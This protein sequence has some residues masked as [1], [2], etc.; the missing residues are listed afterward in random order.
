MSPDEIGRKIALLI[1]YSRDG[2]DGGSRW[3][4]E[5]LRELSHLADELLKMPPWET[6]V[7]IGNSPWN[8]PIPTADPCEGKPE[9]NRHGAGPF[10]ARR[11]RSEIAALLSRQKESLS[12]T[13]SK[14]FEIMSELSG[15]RD[16]APD[17]R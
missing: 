9:P 16:D 1:D 4:P 13:K 8:E 5:M 6:S 10:D 7:V 2:R 17:R 12:H 11:A 3:S 14:I 15:D